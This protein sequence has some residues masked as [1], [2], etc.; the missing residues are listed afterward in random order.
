MSAEICQ[1]V[2]LWQWRESLALSAL[3]SLWGAFSKL[4]SAMV[5]T[6]WFGAA[7]EAECCLGGLFCFS[8]SIWEESFSYQ[9][10]IFRSVYRAQ[11]GTSAGEVDVRICSLSLPQLEVWGQLEFRRPF[12]LGKTDEMK[13]GFCAGLFFFFFLR[14]GEKEIMPKPCVF[15]SAKCC[16]LWSY[17][18]TFEAYKARVSVIWN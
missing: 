11:D 10:W 17:W 4:T 12:S 5:Q 16:S 15:N 8:T 18:L 13:A 14:A 9:S 6:V 3:L 7:A 2:D 1:R